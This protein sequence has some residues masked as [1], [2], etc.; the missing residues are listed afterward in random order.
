METGDV[1]FDHSAAQRH[2]ETVVGAGTE[3]GGHRARTRV[4][5]RYIGGDVPDSDRV[6]Y[7]P[8]RNAARRQVGLVIAHPD[9]MERQRADYRDVHLAGRDAEF[10]DSA[11]RTQGGPQT[12]E[13]RAEHNDAAHRANVSR[14]VAAIQR[15]DAPLEANRLIAL[16]RG[17]RINVV[18]RPTSASRSC[19][20]NVSHRRLISCGGGS[21]TWLAPPSAV[22]ADPVVKIDKSLARNTAALAISSASA[23]RPNGI[24]A[25]RLA[26]KS[27][28][29][30]PGSVWRA[31]LSL[32]GVAVDPAMT[33]LTLIP[34]SASSFAQVRAKARTAA[35][36]AP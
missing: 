27:A 34:R 8:Q 12:S 13:P 31:R 14:Q 29:E 2:H 4:D 20:V 23:K 36:V 30:P 33:T 35:L 17:H 28:T 11:G 15:P 6:E 7:I 21:Q 24:A 19:R 10:V 18:L 9:V 5:R 32:P 1:R 16:G 22:T 26:R 3:R 25:V